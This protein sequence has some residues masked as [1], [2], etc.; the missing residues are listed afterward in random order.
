M[1]EL[2]AVIAYPQSRRR[3]GLGVIVSAYPGFGGYK[4]VLSSPQKARVA[5]RGPVDSADLSD[6]QPKQADL[7]RA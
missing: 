3:P 2:Q 1:E 6:S 5:A 7:H 4:Y